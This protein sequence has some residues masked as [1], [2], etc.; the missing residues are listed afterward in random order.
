MIALGHN[1]GPGSA[2]LA[3]LR[4][5]AGRVQAELAAV[6]GGAE[7]ELRDGL[8]EWRRFDTGRFSAPSRLAQCPRDRAILADATERLRAS[9]EAKRAGQVA[10]LERKL[11]RILAAMAKAEGVG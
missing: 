10:Q 6:R 9:A 8:H 4:Q 5:A 2:H 7:A 11:A 3:Q 1:G